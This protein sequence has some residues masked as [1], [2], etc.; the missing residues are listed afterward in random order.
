[1]HQLGVA[2]WAIEAF[3]HLIAKKDLRLQ[4]S[5]LVTLVDD[6]EGILAVSLIEIFQER[7][8]EKLFWLLQRR[9]AMNMLV[10]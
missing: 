9:R 5:L 7:S 6:M 4:L 1:M 3:S 8:S 10:S 2:K